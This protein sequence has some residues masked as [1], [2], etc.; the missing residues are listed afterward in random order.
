[1][2]PT[3]ATGALRGDA[4]TGS[5]TTEPRSATQNVEWPRGLEWL[6]PGARRGLSNNFVISGTRTASGRPL[7]A[8]DPHLQLEFPSIWYEMH[9][10]AAGLDVVGVTIPGAPFVIIGHNA[11]VAWGVTNTGAD[12]Q[13]LYIERIDLGRRRYFSRGQ[14]LP[15]EVLAADIPVRGR[16]TEP[17]EVWRTQHG[18][19]FAELGLEWD[20]PP[21]WL[22]RGADRSGE[23]RAFALRW[24]ISGEMAGAFEALN[25][26][27]NWTDF[28]AA[29]ERFSAPSQNF[30]FADVDGN[31]GYAMSGVLPLRADGSGTTPLDGEKG[32]GEWAGRVTPATL[33]RVFNP[34]TGY[35]TSSNNEVDRHWNGMI[36]RDWAAPF[37]ALRLHHVL[38]SMPKISV[39][40][41]M[42]L[43][44]DLVSLA[45]EQVLAGTEA[46]I[47]VAR[48]AGANEISI[49][50]LEQLR[51]WDRRVDGRPVA[52]LYQA[53]EDALWRRTFA[54]EM[55]EELFDVFY[56]W[57]GAERPSGLYAII[58]EPGSRWFDDI[59]TID[60]KETR[61][62]IFVLAARDA[63]DRLERDHGNSDGWDW[64]SIHAAAFTHPISAGAF[65]LR[66][67]F[68]RGPSNLPGDGTTVM[69]VS[70]NRLRPFGAWEIPS[71]RQV[72]DVGNWDESRV[73]LPTGQSGHPMSAHYYDQNEMWRR[74]DY[75]PQPFSRA[76]V[77]RARAH[78]LL[79]V[80]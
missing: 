38:T 59:G 52:A 25:R 4:T 56:E 35:V 21:T 39:S 41:A 29:V 33:P 70:F 51:G 19:I 72:L 18:A 13:D 71:W 63:M 40:N 54:D 75:R 3:T 55:G 31:I 34:G 12:V 10:V 20:E 77:D 22:T 67:L 15:V 16:A 36:T 48:R 46:A 26:A 27:A 79:L 37:R 76:G 8:N 47:K 32:E 80:P 11:R 53:F 65:P 42:H 58:D 62:D 9:L 2:Q 60:R 61:D 1:V 68:D 7:L 45:A 73:V 69:R 74:G 30:V 49:R 24:D 23:R 17:F 66:W 14:W 64:S 43:Q 28:T 50:V 78:R 5:F 44:N 6:D 57:A